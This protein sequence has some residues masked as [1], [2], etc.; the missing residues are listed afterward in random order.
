MTMTIR[1]SR[2]LIAAAALALCPLAFAQDP[3]PV[4]G[5]KFPK[6]IMDA[7]SS[8]HALKGKIYISRDG[9][10]ERT[11]V[12]LKKEGLPDW[13]HQVADEKLG[14]GEDIA[15][16]VEVYGDGTEVFEIARRVDGKPMK[17][18][19]RRDRQV[20]YVETTVDRASLPAAVSAALG[21]IEGFQPDECRRRQG[22][23]TEFHIQ[24]AIAGVP[25]RARI[26]A[27][28]TIQSLDRRLAAELEV[29][30]LVSEPA[31]K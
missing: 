10:I 21:K 6:F 19:I 7:L 25:H 8:P 24:G 28:G 18:S 29:A 14:K 13:T 20:R 30:V 17:V 2:L 5:S 4:P 15:Y 27:D 23:T 9:T 11:K 1:R 26:R 12:H 31:A 16:E 22:E 3:A